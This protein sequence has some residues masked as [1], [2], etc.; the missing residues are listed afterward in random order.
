MDIKQ[1]SDGSAG[2][3]SD[4]EG[5]TLS[6]VGGPKS[7]TGGV[8]ATANYRTIITAAIPMAAVSS[9]T[10]TTGAIA[11]IQLEPT[12]DIVITD[13]KIYISATSPGTSIDVGTSATSGASA[14]NLFSFGTGAIGITDSPS[15]KAT[16]LAAGG[17]VT[18][19]PA[20]T[21]ALLAGTLYID[22]HKA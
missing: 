14:S 20:A 2:F 6:R 9:G 21:V 7:P 1:L 12:D 13:A 22:Y 5:K 10:I 17:Y 8:S 15:K 18:A 11:N 4:P 19:T 3:Y 16:Y